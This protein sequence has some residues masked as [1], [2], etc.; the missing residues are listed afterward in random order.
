MTCQTG[1]LQHP[2]FTSRQT[3]SR[4]AVKP[5]EQRDV[6]LSGEVAIQREELRH[7]TD[8]IARRSFWDLIDDLASHGTTVLVST[9]YMEEAEYCHRLALMNRGQLIAVAAPKVLRARMGQPILAIDTDDPARAVDV[10]RDVIGI[11]DVSM[12][13]RAVRAVVEDATSARQSLAEALA[14]SG[15][16][17][18]QVVEVSPSLEDVFVAEV[19]KKGGV[20]V[21]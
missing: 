12:Y 20:V 1:H 2:F 4:N 10:L 14:Q 16:R 6:F 8:A 9:H 15:I 5:G 19:R 7:V 3:A 18:G 13:G 11:I 21:G 17:C